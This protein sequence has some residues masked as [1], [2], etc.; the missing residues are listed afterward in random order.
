MQRGQ[1]TFYR[2]Y[3]EA[4]KEL[5]KREA[6]AVLMAVCAY[7]LDEEEPQLSGIARA[8]F[9]L[10]KPTLDAG[11][12][13]AEGGTRGTPGG[14]KKKER[15]EKEQG[16]TGE[17]PGKDRRNKKENERETEEE[18]ESEIEGEGENECYAP[19]PIP[20]GGD[21]P[22]RGAEER[23]DYGTYGWVKLTQREHESLLA[24]MGE[25]ELERCI[26]Y[27]DES[28]Q[29]TGNKNGWKDWAL[30]VQSCH[31]DRWGIKKAADPVSART[32]FQPSAQRIRENGKWLDDFI[33]SR[34]MPAPAG[35]KE[36][37]ENGTGAG[38]AHF[39]AQ[40]PD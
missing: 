9:S 36:P 33:E 23:A 6:T 34:K 15:P 3:F 30:V 27:V 17:R 11:R 2:S 31:R 5:N 22:S 1:F 8:V 12:K 21:L 28:A 18:I 25:E 37:N 24:R 4:V 40:I 19:S 32:D 13:K 29:K 26:T 16:K 14:G 39:T 35:G 38:T 10:I 20:Q 7:A